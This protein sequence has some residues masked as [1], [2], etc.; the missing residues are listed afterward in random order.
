M[1]SSMANTATTA[2]TNNPSVISRYFVLAPPMTRA[3]A[4]MHR[5]TRPVPRSGCVMMHRNGTIMMPKAFTYSRGSSRLP[6]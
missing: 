4:A 5:Y 1:T 3:N 6:P 2:A